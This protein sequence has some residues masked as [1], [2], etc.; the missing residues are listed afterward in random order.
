MK[1]LNDK[2]DELRPRDLNFRPECDDYRCGASKSWTEGF[3][4][5]AAELLPQIEKLVEALTKIEKDRVVYMNGEVDKNLL[6]W[7]AG[8]AQQ[9]IAEWRK[10]KGEV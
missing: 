7:A 2:R 10:F 4:A 8:T 3:D 9:A 1:S 5:C 6:T